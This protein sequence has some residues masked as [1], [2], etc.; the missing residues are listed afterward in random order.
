MKH[1]YAVSAIALVASIGPLQAQVENRALKFTETG[2]VD[3]GAMPRLDKLASYSLQFW[4]NPN[5]WSKDATLISRGDNVSVKL[6]SSNEIVFNIDGSSLAAS[7]Q[8]L[9]PSVWTQ[10]TMICNQGKGTVYVNGEEVATGMLK[11]IPESIDSFVLGG[12]YSGLLDEVRI[13]NEA[14]DDSMK[15]FDY[16]TNNTLNKWCSMWDNLVAYYKMD[17]QDCP[18]LVDYKGVGDPKDDYDNHG[19]LSEGVTKVS[20]ENE[21]MP[22]LVNAAY[23]ENIRFFD[24]IIPRDQYLLSNEIIIL[25]A[26]CVAAT[27]N[28]VPRTPNNHA[29][30][31]GATYLST[32]EGREGVLSFDGK[33]STRLVAPSATFNK[34][35]KF[36]FETWLYLEEWTPGAYLFRK[37]TADGKNG[38]SLR[39][40]D[41]ANNPTLIARVNGNEFVSQSMSIPV[42]KWCHVGLAPGSGGSVIRALLF[43]LD[44][45]SIRPNVSLSSSEY[46]VTPTGNEDEPIY[47]GENLKAKLDETLFW[48]KVIALSDEKNHMTNVPMPGLNKNANVIDIT[49]CSA[50]YTFDNEENLGHSSHSQ[51]EWAN[52]MRSAYEGHYPAKIT[53]SVRGHDDANASDNYTSIMN[54]EAK[55]KI[56]AQDLAELS[57]NY[58]G[59]ELDLEWIYNATA[60]SNYHKL[61]KEIIAA[62]PEGKTFRISTHNVTY[63]YPKG[64]DG[65]ENPGITGFTFQQ[66]GP[67]KTHFNY[68]TFTNYVN[69]FLNY[70][71]PADKIMTSYSTTTSNGFLNDG[72]TKGGDIRGWRLGTLK[73]YVEGDQVIDKYTEGNITW[74][75]IGPMQVYK[76]AKFTREK[77]L[78]GI[79]YWDMGNDNWSGTAAAPVMEKYHAA[80]YCSY[81]INANCDTIVTKLNVNHYGESGVNEIISDKQES[82]G[83]VVTPSPADSEISVYLTN[84]ELPVEVKIYSLAGSL[85]KDTKQSHGIKVDN[86]VSGVYMVTA[87]DSKGKLWKTKFVKR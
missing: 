87:K 64:A 70:G 67:Q 37:E 10:V 47:I 34:G 24:R 69:N 59:V 26:D 13:W 39:L 35:D 74:S 54:N 29:T 53:L 12:N 72:D 4:L 1:F 62:L 46:N 55:R 5:T 15:Q 51:D 80:K 61:S 65:I 49:D 9:N 45:D 66:Y 86:L 68:N 71:Y 60:W 41:D 84:G 27:G 38:L 8:A 30:V 19:I 16:F 75:Y 52:I 22:Y 73:D 44:E 76:R 85:V 2:T 57:K 42:G 48:N 23:T 14:L 50:Y 20:A 25:G 56:F 79:F 21:K 77:N 11:E 83:I 81:G 31:E 63:E 78:Q 18:F 43:F 58:D 32:Y 36:S 6:G 33:S 17:Q 82:K 3:C 28:V 40:G 7:S